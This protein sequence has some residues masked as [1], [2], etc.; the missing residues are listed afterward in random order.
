M[1]QARQTDLLLD[2]EQIRRRSMRALF[3]SLDRLCQGT[4]VVDRN[5]RIV[6]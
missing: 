3:E 2:Q 1:P 4:V 5:A 6:Q